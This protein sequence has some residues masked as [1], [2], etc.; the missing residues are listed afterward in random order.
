MRHS[1]TGYDSCR[2]THVVVFVLV[3]NG[4][5]NLAHG[6]QLTEF[7]LLVSWVMAVVHNVSLLH[8]V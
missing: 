2:L 5:G 1:L 7:P 6:A 4:E 8:L 3:L